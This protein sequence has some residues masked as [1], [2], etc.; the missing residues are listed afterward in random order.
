M[1]TFLSFFGSPI[2][3]SF[4]NHWKRL[5][6]LIQKGDVEKVLQY[7]RRMKITPQLFEKVQLEQDKLTDVQRSHIASLTSPV[8]MAAK[9]GHVRIMTALLDM[10]Y[11]AFDFSSGTSNPWPIFDVCARG[12]LDVART[13]IEVHHVDVESRDNNNETILFAAVR[14]GHVDIVDYLVKA[15]ASLNKPHSSK[16]YFSPLHVTVKTPGPRQMDMCDF[17]LSRGAD[18]NARDKYGR[19]PLF[20]LVLDSP[21]RDALS[22]EEDIRYP[23]YRHPEDFLNL[24]RLVCSRGADLNMRSKSGATP[25][26]TAS[27][28]GKVDIV[29]YLAIERNASLDLLYTNHMERPFVDGLIARGQFA[30][31][32]TIIEAGYD[33]I[34]KD[35]FIERN[36]YW[37]E[38]DVEEIVGLI[39]ERFAEP[40]SLLELC[41]FKIRTILGPRLPF[42]IETIPADEGLKDLI[43]LKHVQN[44]SLDIEDDVDD[45]EIDDKIDDGE[46]HK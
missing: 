7:I 19:S 3:S 42:V 9:L 8:C 5:N 20:L 34:A 32:Q 22:S 43:K 1:S 39:R 16:D 37:L 13:L 24:I 15:G 14:G 27:I 29:H 44:F 33:V 35:S 40:R 18:V 36:L 26:F 28:Y 4:L 38:E 25:L 21:G 2:S 23:E 45:D 31:L 30:A 46:E 10:G 6:E 41:C 17:L 12:H 11:P